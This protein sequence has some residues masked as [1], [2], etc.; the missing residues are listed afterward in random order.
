[1]KFKNQ[2]MLLFSFN[3]ISLWD[4]S[5]FATENKEINEVESFGLTK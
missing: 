1:M 2:L 4:R 3:C 5:C